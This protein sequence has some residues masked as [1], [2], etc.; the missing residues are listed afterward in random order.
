[1]NQLSSKEYAMSYVDASPS[2]LLHNS[3]EK[4]ICISL[5]YYFYLK[6]SKLKRISQ[7]KKTRGLKR[8]L[9]TQ[10]Y[11]IESIEKKLIAPVGLSNWN[12]REIA[13]KNGKHILKEANIVT[14]QKEYHETITIGNEQLSYGHSI[15]LGWYSVVL[16]TFLSQVGKIAKIENKNNAVIFLDLLSGDKINNLRSFNVV[17]YIIDNSE[18]SNFQIET[19]KNNNLDK[20]G[21]AYGT[22]NGTT[23]EIKNDYEYVITDW[24]VQSFHSLLKYEKGNLEKTSEEY[25]LSEL[26]KYLLNKGVFIIKNAID[27]I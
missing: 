7:F 9:N 15:S 4:Y 18:L 6:R 12:Y 8:K 5:V 24:I 11:I 22:K 13:L 19:I 21:F 23:K 20:L 10:K 25:Q 2:E 14:N 1:M 26:A 16:A 27:L 17:E 3:N